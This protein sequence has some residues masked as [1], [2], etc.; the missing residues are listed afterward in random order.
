MLN[1]NILFELYK[2]EEQS[3]KIEALPENFESD[4]KALILD[5]SAKS[6][7]ESKKELE[8]IKFILNSIICARLE[9]IALRAIRSSVLD[10]ANLSEHEK[11]FFSILNNLVQEQKNAIENLVNKEEKKFLK[12]LILKDIT[13]YV[14]QEGK[15]LG[16]FK[17]G[18]IL[19]LDQSEALWLKEQ[20]LASIL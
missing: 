10:L 20:G 11:K 15:L 7:L 17:N 16:P 1:Y 12:I 3:N 18:Q 6:D 14:S 9:K 2:K 8:N 4:L 5:L 19:E 13:E